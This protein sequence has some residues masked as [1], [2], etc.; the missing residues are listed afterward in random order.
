[1]SEE[2]PKKIFRQVL[3]GVSYCS[4]TMSRATLRDIVAYVYLKNGREITTEEASNLTKSALAQLCN[5]GLIRNSHNCYQ[6]HDA[7]NLSQPGPVRRRTTRSTRRGA[8]I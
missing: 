3:K 2:V 1:M 4:R 6:L 7:L 8:P 5:S